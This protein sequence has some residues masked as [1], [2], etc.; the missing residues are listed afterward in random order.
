MIFSRA[1]ASTFFFRAMSIMPGDILSASMRFL[2]CFGDRLLRFLGVYSKET[3]LPLR[4]LITFVF[5][6]TILWRLLIPRL[7]IFFLACHQR[8]RC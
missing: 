6:L 7:G 5:F 8:R 1:S 4:S 3:I 2:I